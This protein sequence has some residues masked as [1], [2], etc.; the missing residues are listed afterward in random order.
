MSFAGKIDAISEFTSDVAVL[1]PVIG[2]EDETRGL[3]VLN[4]LLNRPPFIRYRDKEVTNEKI[5]EITTAQAARVTPSMGEV[6]LF[7]KT[8]PATSIT[9]SSESSIMLYGTKSLFP[10]KEPL[11]TA[12][13]EVMISPGRT[14][15]KAFKLRASENIKDS[16]SLNR[17]NINTIGIE[18]SKLKTTPAVTVECMLFSSLFVRNLVIIL[19]TVMGIPEQVIVKNNPKIVNAI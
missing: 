6:A 10:Q 4:G 19:E 11:I 7:I 13:T 12:Y 17:K 1:M 15:I 2:R 5:Y 14:I 16:L 18:T 8:T 9:A 3:S